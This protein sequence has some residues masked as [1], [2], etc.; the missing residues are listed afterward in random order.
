[1]LGGL[2]HPPRNPNRCT[3]SFHLTAERQRAHGSWEFARGHLWVSGRAGVGWLSNLAT[4]S[5]LRAPFQPGT[6]ITVI[7]WLLNGSYPFAKW[8][9]TLLPP[10]A[11]N[12]EGQVRTD[13]W[14]VCLRK[15]RPSPAYSTLVGRARRG[16][17]ESWLLIQC[18]FYFPAF[19]SLS[20]TSPA[21]GKMS[22][23]EG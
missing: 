12:W 14:C 9:H 16:T 8:L 5:G 21:E 6:G 4:L 22:G 13:S 7:G 2:C 3:L 20:G 1:M 19:F 11:L 17:Q 15:L 18:S 23:W 10:L